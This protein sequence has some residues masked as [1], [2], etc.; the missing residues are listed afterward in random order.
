MN[1]DI[2]TS[3]SAPDASANSLHREHPPTKTLRMFD[4]PAVDALP[5]DQLARSR[6]AAEV[7]TA[8]EYAI[9]GARTVLMPFQL[10][11]LAHMDGAV[12]DIIERSRRVEGLSVVTGAWILGGYRS[13]RTFIVEHQAEARLL[14]GDI[15]TQSRLL[16]D[17]IGWLR[18]RGTKRSTINSYWRAMVFVG[19]RLQVGTGMVNIFRLLPAPHPGAS[20]LRCLTREQ[21]TQ[22]LAW[23]LHFDWRSSFLRARNAAIIATLLLAGLRRNE[24]LQLLFDDVDLDN[25]VVHVRAGKGRHGGKP[26]SIPMTAQLHR[27]LTRYV[28]ARRERDIV[29]TAFFVSAREDAPLNL[30]ALKRLFDLVSTATG[31]HVS[32]HML[33]HT[34]CTLLSQSGMSDRLA[35]SAMGHADLRMLQRYQHIYSGEVAREIQKL[36]LDLP[37]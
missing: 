30:T 7:R 10:P 14:K 22:V 17:W 24:A 18:A 29:T 33:R 3:A 25:A 20:R 6:Y 8:A 16:E 1:E 31:I 4:V 19:A 5:H 36:R 34:F 12:R 37:L 21:A 23:V 28:D 27:I 35:M 26:R 9:P 2:D 15:H 32:P 11:S 13:L